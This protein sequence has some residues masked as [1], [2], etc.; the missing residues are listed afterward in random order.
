MVKIELSVCRNILALF[1]DNLERFRELL[2]ST[3]LRLVTKFEP[4]TSWSDN[5]SISTA[6]KCVLKTVSDAEGFVSILSNLHLLVEVLSLLILA[7]TSLVDA[8]LSSLYSDLDNKFHL[9]ANQNGALLNS[10][11][12]DRIFLLI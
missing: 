5:H 9:A 4:D 12:S 2:I 1:W 3:L 8:D 7:N 6:M 10:K 11:N